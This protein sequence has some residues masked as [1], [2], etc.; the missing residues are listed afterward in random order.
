[1]PIGSSD[2]HIPPIH[3][4]MMSL[5]SALAA[6]LFTLTVAS[7]AVA[8]RSDTTRAGIP[9]VN[10]ISTNP[11]GMIF[12]WFNG[13]F[14]H[15]LAP[16]AGLAIAA[17]HFSFDEFSYTNVDGIIRYYPNARAIRGFAFGGSVGFV[18]AGVDDI[19]CIDCEDGSGF[20][21]GVRG[22]YVWLMGRDQHFAVAAGLGA[23]RLFYREG[24][25]SGSTALPIG[26]LSIGFAW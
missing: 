26:R 9:R 14:E 12:E 13:E 4:L 22:D 10:L 15:A 2:Q 16:T 20:T 7:S 18:R 23:K 1:V 17:S 19:N 11:I 6:G 24:G 25:S 3:L 5:R 21:L 8:Q